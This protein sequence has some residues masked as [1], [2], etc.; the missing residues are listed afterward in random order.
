MLP[1]IIEAMTHLKTLKSRLDTDVTDRMELWKR[2][3]VAQKQQ[4][5]YI[6]QSQDRLN[7]SVA[8]SISHR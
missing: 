1:K 4:Q 3:E 5:S 2:C 6:T 8:R 7:V